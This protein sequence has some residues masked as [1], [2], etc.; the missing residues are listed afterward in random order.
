MAPFNAWGSTA[1]RLEPLRGGNLP[2]LGAFVNIFQFTMWS[3]L[4]NRWSP[5]SDVFLREQCSFH[6]I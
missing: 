1:S 4:N 3:R 5:T 6:L 2:F